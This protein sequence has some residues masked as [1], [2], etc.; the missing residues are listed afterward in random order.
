MDHRQRRKWQPFISFAIAV[1]ALIGL[2][3]LLTFSWRLF[4]PEAGE[5]IP[6]TELTET[7]RELAGQLLDDVHYLAEEIGMRNMQYP[8]S[9]EKT[10]DWIESRFSDSGYSPHRHTYTIGG[11]FSTGQASDNIIAEIPGSESPGQIVVIGAHY[12]S[13]TGSPG[14]NDNASAVAVLLAL[15][16]WFSDQPQPKTI[17]FVAFA[18]EEPPFFHSSNMG[19]YQYAKKCKERGDDITAMMALDGL[20]YYSDEPGSQKYPLPGIGLFYPDKANF[21]GF[22][23]RLRDTGLMKRALSAFRENAG[24]ASEGAALPGFIPGVY[25]SDH[26]SFWKHGY[27][28]FL[29]TDTLIF[30]DPAYHRPT[31]TPDRLD[32][33]RMALLTT[34]LKDVVKKLSN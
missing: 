30:R 16:E 2:I 21:I 14:A 3:V 5:E 8:G 20:G 24:I 15:A 29:V 34:G 33:D 13:V 23:T 4:M 10:A 17:R 22:V 28:A 19:S 6:M 26:W 11:I 12:D 25:W 7:E 18:N 9:M 1:T 31:D 27:P 32:Y